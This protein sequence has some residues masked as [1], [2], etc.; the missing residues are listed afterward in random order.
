VRLLREHLDD[1][2]AVVSVVGGYDVTETAEDYVGMAR[3][4]AEA[5]AIGVSIYDWPTTPPSAWAPMQ[6]YAVPRC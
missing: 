2:C 4:A 3:A 1:P 6:G 5:G